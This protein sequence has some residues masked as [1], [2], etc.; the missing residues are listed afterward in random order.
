MMNIKFVFI[1]PEDH[2]SVAGEPADDGSATDEPV[3]FEWYLSRRIKS[4]KLLTEMRI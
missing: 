1:I 2:G 3:R 4:H